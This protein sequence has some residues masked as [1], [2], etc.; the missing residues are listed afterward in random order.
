MGLLVGFLYYDVDTSQVSVQDR[1]GALYFVLTTQIFSAQ[2]SLRV[3]LEER[4]LFLR[5]HI[6]GAYSTGAYYWAKSLADT[7]LQLFNALLFSL[8]GYFLVGLQGSAYHLVTYCMTIV[9]TTLAAESYVVFVGAAA[10]DDL[11][12]FSDTVSTQVR[13]KLKAR[14]KSCAQHI[15]VGV[16]P[17]VVLRFG[18][19]LHSFT[20]CTHC[21][22]AGVHTHVEQTHSPG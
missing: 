16:C 19:R 18:W 6:A 17:F 13:Q 4:D 7:P 15:E 20:H 5:E 8:L 22:C 10:P 21:K 2:A 9:I 12:L 1:T 11:L 14:V 3:F